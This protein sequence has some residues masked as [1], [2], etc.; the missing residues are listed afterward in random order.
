M[1]TRM[2]NRTMTFVDDNITEDLRDLWLGR[3]PQTHQKNTQLLSQAKVFL[4]ESAYI[5]M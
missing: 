1:E 4:R 3:V 5:F 2:E